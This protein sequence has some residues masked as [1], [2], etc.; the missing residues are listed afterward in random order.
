MLKHSLYN[1]HKEHKYEFLMDLWQWKNFFSTA[2]FQIL[3]VLEAQAC[4][5]LNTTMIFTVDCPDERFQLRQ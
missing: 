4:V 5:I 2:A 1:E 3:M